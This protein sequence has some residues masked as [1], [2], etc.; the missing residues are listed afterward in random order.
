[1]SDTSPQKAPRFAPKLKAKAILDEPGKS[2]SLRLSAMIG[3]GALCATSLLLVWVL[4]FQSDNNIEIELNTVTT[5]K[6]GR[7]ELQGLTYKGKTKAGDPYILTAQKAAEDA[8]NST[9][10]NLTGLDGEITNQDNGRITLSSE[11]GQFSQ[12]DNHLKLSGN[13]TLTQSARDLVLETHALSGDLEAGNFTA[14]QAVLVK[15]PS[16][17]ITSQAML[18]E[19]FGDKI[20]FQGQS[21]AIIEGSK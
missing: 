9:I 11:Q 12:A 7:L 8:V 20:I 15:S 6:E 5:T 17:K 16:S 18:V 13:V 1:M 3:I 19:N 10:V 21:K 2:T 14:P 4:F